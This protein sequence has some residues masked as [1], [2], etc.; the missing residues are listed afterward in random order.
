MAGVLLPTWVLLVV[1]G[2]SLFAPAGVERAIIFPM[3]VVP[4]VWGLWN[5]LYVS[6]FRTRVP[7]GVF[8][9]F[10]PVLLVPAG[11]ALANALEVQFYT[12]KH[13]AMASPFV[14]AIYYLAWKYAVALFNRTVDLR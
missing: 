10:L 5:V 9:A 13:A 7:I 14:M 1:L 6:R 4:N 12:A 3:A 2:V 8:G 11:L